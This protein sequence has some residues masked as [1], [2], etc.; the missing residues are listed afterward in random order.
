[1]ALNRIECPEC[2]AGLKSSEGFTL[3]ESVDCPKCESSFTVEDAHAAPSDGKSKKRSKR[4][5]ESERGY[6]NSPMRYAVLGVLVAVMIVL[7]VMLF[8]KKQ[9]DREIEE[10][11]AKINAQE[12]GGNPDPVQPPGGGLGARVG[13]PQPFPM[14]PNP[15][16]KG[17]GF[18]PVP[19]KNPPTTGGGP[20][21]GNG[22]L[23]ETPFNGTPEYNKL[24]VELR[25][26]LAGT[27][28]GAAPDGTVHKATYQGNGQF[29]LDVGGKTSS[30][31]WQSA[32]LVGGK[33]LKIT[34]GTPTA[35]KVVFEGDEIIHD[36]DTAGVSIVMKKK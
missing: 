17:P 22:I 23:A 19:K 18:V 13:G 21:G 15:G 2:G 27:W 26:K 8:Q 25:Q 16:Q 33:V 4:D 32:G 12:P 29:T 9:R 31:T 14:P 10:E 1:M 11:N 36:T 7:G 5:D 30:G 24:V 28:E 3:G 35:Y 20:V 6:K 34:R